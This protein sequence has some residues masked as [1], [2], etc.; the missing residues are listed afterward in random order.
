MEISLAAEPVFNIGSFPVTNSLLTAWVV[1]AFIMVISIVVS[2]KINRVP[3]G[4][5]NLFES[6]F[7]YFLGVMDSVTG[8]KKLS[9]RFFPI[10][11]TIFFFVLL[12]NWIGLLP[13]VGTVGLHELHDGHEV[14]VPL[15][16]A[17]SADLNFTIAVALIAVSATHFF[18][19]AVLGV[20]KH[21][22]KFISLKNLIKD[23]I[24][25]FVGILEIVGEIAKAISFSFRLFG[26]IFAGEVLLTVVALLVPYV[27]PLPFLFLEIF[28]GLIQAVVF[29]MLTLVF[30]SLQTAEHEH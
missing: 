16:R 18:G 5:H 11:A 1:V 25:F 4:I 27:A 15:F 24:M 7:E 30:L 14:F 29:S 17:G 12:N 3:T 19:I 28:V 26:N 23:P 21:V 8:S 2:K 9:R 6:V 10:V 22:A 13:G 20:R